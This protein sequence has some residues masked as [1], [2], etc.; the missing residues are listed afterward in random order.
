MTPSA[1]TIRR[2]DEYSVRHKSI[3]DEEAVTKDSSIL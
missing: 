2:L 1:F 3:Y